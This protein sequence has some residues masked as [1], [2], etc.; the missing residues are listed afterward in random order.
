MRLPFLLLTCLLA[1]LSGCGGNSQSADP[2][3][4][5]SNPPPT[6]PGTDPGSGTD[7]DPD[8]DPEPGDGDGGTTS[9]GDGGGDGGTEPPP[10][11]EN[12]A[13]PDVI[14]DAGLLGNTGQP[15][16]YQLDN[17]QEESAGSG[18]S[19]TWIVTMAHSEQSPQ[20]AARYWQKYVLVV[21]DD[22]LGGYEAA[23]CAGQ[24]TTTDTTTTQW[25]DASG[26]PV[27]A[28]DPSASYQE[29]VVTG[30]SDDPW[31]AFRPA[32]AAAHSLTLPLLSADGF[33]VEPGIVLSGSTASRLSSQD[34]RYQAHKITLAGT[35]LGQSDATIDATAF[36][37]Q[38]VWCVVQQLST[39]RSCTNNT[40]HHDASIRAATAENLQMLGTRSSYPDHEMLLSVRYVVSGSAADSGV[41]TVAT[42]KAPSSFSITATATQIEAGIAL[43]EAA[44]S[45]NLTTT[46]PVAP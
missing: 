41:K 31:H 21:R 37:Q 3:P 45:I 30:S 11:P 9:P 23:N 18:L 2:A 39:E 28:G 34:G 24:T 13:L 35:A 14:T 32:G 46:I 36:A 27:T 7:P 29:E 25:Y 22:G 4:D 42:L 20:T 16:T 5:S 19:G 15:A 12:C 44:G 43:T 38:D 1:L 8:P 17:T 10:P 33:A 26:T 40:L 6:D